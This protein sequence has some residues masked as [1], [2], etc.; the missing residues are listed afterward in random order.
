ML[1]VNTLRKYK[2]I[3]IRGL[4]RDENYKVGDIC[5][6]SYQWDYENDISTYDTDEPEELDGTCA[7]NT[8]ID[9]YFDEDEEII[10]KINNSLKNFEYDGDK[11][12]VAGNDYSFG[13]DENEIIIEEAEVI[14]IF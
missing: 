11:V 13:M 6:P 2:V 12:L 4:T 3:G 9:T 7:K 8:G 5:R 10:E 14:H 1:D